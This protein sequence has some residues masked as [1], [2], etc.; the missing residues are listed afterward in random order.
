VAERKYD[1]EAQWVVNLICNY[2]C[3][4]CIS[5]AP[6]DPFLVGKLSPQAYADFFDSTGKTWLLHLSGGEPFA[7]RG[8]VELCAALAQNHL[9]ALNSNLT[10]RRVRAFAQAVDPRRV[11]YI[12]CGVHPEERE[13]RNGWKTLL[14]NLRILVQAG[15]PVYSSCVMTPAAFALFEGASRRLDTVEVPLIPKLLRGLHRGRHYP[16]NYSGQEREQFLR[17]SELAGRKIRASRFSPLR[18]DPTVN[19]LIDRY[20]LHGTPD[21]T[22]VP[23]SAGRK[24][25]TIAP[26]GNIYACGS[27]GRIGNIFLRRL[28]LYSTDQPC[29]SEWCHYVCVRYSAVDATHAQSLPAIPL[30]M[31]LKTQVAGLIHIAQRGAVNTL[32]RL[33][34]P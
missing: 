5:S 16:Q 15:F 23:C 25:V 28:K 31:P 22:G 9:I 8:F 1:I 11:E 29:R 17:F 34:L 33:S 7:Y 6:K 14:P 12:H 10:S 3:D 13:K 18:N 30:E 27:A 26:D 4:Y 19:P 21:F 20:F 2:S 32:V 24:I